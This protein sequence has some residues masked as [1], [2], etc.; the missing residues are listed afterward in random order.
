MPR[1]GKRV[2]SFQPTWNLGKTRLIRVPEVL[3]DDLL[4]RAKRLDAGESKLKTSSEL[5]WQAFLDEMDD[6]IEAESN[7][8]G[9]NQH[10]KEFSIETRDWKKFKK[11]RQKIKERKDG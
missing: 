6:F 10:K 7:S 11:F 5:Y 2:T 1:G 3:A 9:A 8:H 4:A